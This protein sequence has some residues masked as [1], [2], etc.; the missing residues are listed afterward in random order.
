MKEKMRRRPA[1]RMFSCPELLR[2]Q[3]KSNSEQ[4][5]VRRKKE[6]EAKN[7]KYDEEEDKVREER[8]KKVRRVY[9]THMLHA[10]ST[11][12]SMCVASRVIENSDV[13]RLFQ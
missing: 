4:E 8:K 1:L 12:P 11:S 5:K 2:H 13:T 9:E 10:S 3:M 7:E 6:K